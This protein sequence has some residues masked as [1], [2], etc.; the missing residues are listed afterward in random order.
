[1]ETLVILYDKIRRQKTW[2]FLLSIKRYL[3]YISI[4]LRLVNFSIVKK[5]EVFVIIYILIF[6][7]LKQWKFF[8]SP[9]H[10]EYL[11]PL[12]KSFVS[13][14]GLN[15]DMANVPKVINRFKN[16]KDTPKGY[17]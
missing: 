13:K 6:S 1:M 10:N 4:L 3:A 14:F 9:V 16:T 17:L 8:S 2:V 12:G 15:S 5:M 11:K 7:A